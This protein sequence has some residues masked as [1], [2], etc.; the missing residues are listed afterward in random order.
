[1]DDDRDGRMGEDPPSDVN[2]DGIVSWIRVKDPDGEWKEDPTDPR[3]L[4]KADRAKGER[5]VYKLW[6]EGRDSDHDEKVAEDAP[7]DARVDGNFPAGWEQHTPAAGVF[8]TDEPEARG[9]CEFV[10]QH[11]GLSLVVVYDAQ[12]DLVGDVKSVADEAPYVKRIPQEG[13]M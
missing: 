12:D 13:V 5:G 4:V 10:L 2:G 3:A 6:P 11:T 8:P 7:L 1:V 9:L